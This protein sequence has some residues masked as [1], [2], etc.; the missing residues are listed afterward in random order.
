MFAPELNFY[1]SKNNK[2]NFVKLGQH[3]LES[4]KIS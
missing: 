1:N 3:Y 4:C 2:G